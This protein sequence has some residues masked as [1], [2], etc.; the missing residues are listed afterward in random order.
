MSANRGGQVRVG[1]FVSFDGDVCEVAGF[2]GSVVLLL[3]G[4]GRKTALTLA[5]LLG[6]PA[7]EILDAHRRRRPLAPAYFDSLPS[8]IRAKALRLESHVTE[9]LDGIPVG[10]ESGALPRPQYDVTRTTLRQREASKVRELQEA[11]ESIPLRVFQRYRREYTTAGIEALIDKR[12]VRRSRLTARVDERYVEVLRSVLAANTDASTGTALRLKWLVDKAVEAEYGPGVVPIPSR[13]TFNR[14]RTRLRE[15]RHAT[16][17]ART[18][19]TLDNQ[20]DGPFGSVVAT[21]PGEWMEIDS[22]PFDVAVRLDDEVAGR[23]ELTALV[24]VHTR[25]LAAA[26]LRPTTKDVDAALLLARAM[27][28]EP[29]RPGW[30]E[31]VS[32]AYSALPYRTLRSVDDRLDNAAGRPVI[33]PENIVCDNGK[34]FVSTTF[35]NACR[36]F[37]ISLQPAHPDT[38]TDKP[39]VERTLE[40]VKTLFAQYITG[41]LGSSTEYRGTDADQQAVFSLVELQD[42]LDEWIVTAW[43]N[44]KHDGLRDPLNTSRVLTPNEMYAASL[45][46]AGY[47]PVPLSAEDY[48]QLQPVK[49]RRINSYGVKIDHRVYDCEELN[50]YRGQPSGV[51]EYKNKWAVHHDPYDVTRIWIRNHHDGGWITAFWRQLH[52]TP[53]PF[54]DAAWQYARRIVAERGIETPSEDTIKQAVDEL[55]DRASPPVPDRR[56]KKSAKARRIAA[57]TRAANEIP[58]TPTPDPEPLTPPSYFAPESESDELAEV[59]PL[60]V[61]DAEQEAEKWW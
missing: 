7:F 40:S 4:Q 20:P 2:D 37:G 34:V 43:Q 24:D 9:V 60:P 33:V 22:T 28:P 59:I 56:R 54:G 1:D 30:P 29:M 5:A 41:Y 35:L 6:D 14:L 61:F 52:S 46:V 51:N 10:S 31:A 3:N 42:L 32:M 21:R 19:R 18:R 58:P 13:P 23:I 47:V 16:G 25:T 27:T 36:S 45:A 55:L 48:I 44:R 11:G 50:P 17:S 8:E 39:H 12:A 15:A 49:L 26:V 57:R 38:P 53:Q